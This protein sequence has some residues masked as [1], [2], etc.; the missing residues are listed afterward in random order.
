MRYVVKVFVEKKDN[1]ILFRN[2]DSG[3]IRIFSLQGEYIRSEEGLNISFLNTNK[4]LDFLKN[5]TYINKCIYFELID[6]VVKNVFIRNTEYD[7]VWKIEDMINRTTEDQRIEIGME[8]KMSKVGNVLTNVKNDVG[9]AITHSLKITASTTIVNTLVVKVRS[10]CGEH[11]P[12]FFTE[13]E[14]GKLLEPVIISSLFLSLGYSLQ[15][16]NIELPLSDKVMAAVKYSLEGN[17][18]NSLNSFTGTLTTLFSEL[19]T[20]AESFHAA[21]ENK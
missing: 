8:S 6:D 5:D 18:N 17:L 19:G 14:L 9:E 11:Y 16:A 13:T 21:K 12:K 20:A 1:L 4:N 2:Y 15:E 3:L 7:S 10:L